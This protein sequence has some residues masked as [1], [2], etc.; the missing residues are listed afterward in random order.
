MLN[1]NFF[2]VD[3]NFFPVETTVWEHDVFLKVA[4]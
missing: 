2:S 4:V 1:L 3:L